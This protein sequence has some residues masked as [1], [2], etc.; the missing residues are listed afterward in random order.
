MFSID[1]LL[2]VDGDIF[3][4][5]PINPNESYF[6]KP[7][8]GFLLIQ[9]VE[10]LL[11]SSNNNYVV[12]ITGIPKAFGDMFESKSMSIAPVNFQ[13]P[14]DGDFSSENNSTRRR[15][16]LG[17]QWVCQSISPM[18]VAFGGDTVGKIKVFND[19]DQRLAYDGAFNL[20]VTAKWRNNCLY[21]EVAGRWI[22]S[23]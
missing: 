9:S 12:L 11:S 6:G 2:V 19:N 21:T 7:H 14:D 10:T 22:V 23:L 1:S 13:E 3:G 17:R 16:L 5:C 4:S 15:A 20:S 18:S 8:D